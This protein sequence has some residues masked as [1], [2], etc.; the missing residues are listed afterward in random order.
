MTEPEEWDDRW[1]AAVLPFFESSKSDPP[2]LSALV[3][4]L[5]AQENKP[6]P[7][8]FRA[9]LAEI[10]ESRFGAD[11]AIGMNWQL[12]P[13]YRGWHEKRQRETEQEGAIARAMVA[14]GQPV[15]DAIAAID[16]DG[17]MSA[18]TGWTAWTRIKLKR[19]WSE[20]VRLALRKGQNLAAVRKGGEAV[21]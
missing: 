18:R 15:T 1:A 8:A 12:E 20:R 19:A 21:D 7:E 13:V 4:L 10:L 2:D 3:R 16:A 6:L 17:V 5:R 9:M 14:A 11:D